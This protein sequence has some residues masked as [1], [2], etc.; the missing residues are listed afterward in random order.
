MRTGAKVLTVTHVDTGN[1]V[2]A[3]L[4][5]YAKVAREHGAVLILDAVASLGGMPIDMDAQGIDVVLTA[6]QKAL[7]MPPG[8]AIMVVSQRGLEHR[9]NLEGGVGYFLDWLK[10]AATDGRP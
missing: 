10:L 1:G 5:D 2:A 3:P 8:L 9:R 6:S 4:A 7:G